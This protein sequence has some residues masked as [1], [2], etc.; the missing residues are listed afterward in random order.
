MIY[1]SQSLLQ[2]K[3]LLNW[4][5]GII[6]IGLPLRN[7][8]GKPL[9]DYEKII[10][11]PLVTQDGNNNHN[12]H[13]WIKKATELGISEFMLRFMAWLCLIML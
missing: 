5:L 4:S 7:G 13:L 11:D 9:Y 3:R 10:F 1:F 6:F 8:I 12:K 2:E